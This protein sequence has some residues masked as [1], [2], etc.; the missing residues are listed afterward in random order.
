MPDSISE[1]LT[2]IPS[3]AASPG[4]FAAYALAVLSS[5]LIALKVRR[6]QQVLAHLKDFPESQRLKVLE[7]EMGN[8]SV[9]TGLTPE[10]WL[11]SRIHSYLFVGFAAVC[12]VA[13]VVSVVALTSRTTAGSVD[14]D[15]GLYKP[16][17]SA[18]SPG[19]IAAPSA[20]DH[21]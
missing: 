6:N 3:A 16:P 2:A 13:L 7:L 17:I 10:Q 5:T 8:V 18:H 21:P 15:I 4:A 14:T 9:P 19:I 20:S 12:A 1:F 11:R